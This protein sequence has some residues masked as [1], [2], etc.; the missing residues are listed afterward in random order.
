MKIVIV[1]AE[2][3]GASAAAKAKRLAPEAEIIVYEQSEIVSFGACGLPYFLAN[4]FDDTGYMISRT[5]S[6]FARSG[7]TVKTNHQVLAVDPAVRVLT[8][9]NLHTGEQETRFY[10]RLMIATGAAPIKPPIEN[11][12]RKN[13]FTLKTMEDGLAVKQ[14][15][16]SQTVK[17]V[18]IVGAGFIGLEVAEA[19]MHLGKDVRLIQLDE[20]IMADVFDREITEVLEKE[21]IAAGISLHLQETVKAVTGAEQAAG[22]LTDKGEY[23]A[24]LVIVA[25]GVKPNTAFLQNTGLAMLKN[26]AIIIDQ[27]GRTNLPDIYAAGDCATVPHRITGENAYIP[28]ATTANKIGRIVGENLAGKDSQFPGTLGSAAVRVLEAEAG[29]TGIT[30]K[31]AVKA[32]I[33]YGS[34]FIKDKNHSNYLPG[35]SDIFVKLIYHKETRKLLGGQTAGR[36]GAAFRANVLAT[37]VWNGMTIEELGM[38]DLFY[39]PPFSRPWDVLNIAANAVKE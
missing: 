30:E 33:P 19:M 34:V 26:G 7:I 22:V 2:A 28:L 12:H 25:A 13:V 37:A 11:L 24:D 16:Q 8:V 23:P 39:A 31:D 27:S 35:Q 3:A 15:A 1:G 18:V 6:Q 10:D 21:I 5:V 36:Y 29:R 9:R 4:H 32:G 17:N 20:R 14:A 38:L